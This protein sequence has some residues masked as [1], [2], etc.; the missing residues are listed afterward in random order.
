ML[1]VLCAFKGKDGL[2]MEEFKLFIVILCYIL[3]CEY[4][5]FRCQEKEKLLSLLMAINHTLILQLIS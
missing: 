2:T 1:T 3:K 5:Q 4:I